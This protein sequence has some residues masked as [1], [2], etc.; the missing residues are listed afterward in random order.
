MFFLLSKGSSHVSPSSTNI[1]VRFVFLLSKRI[2]TEA[3]LILLRSAS[4]EIERSQEVITIHLTYLRLLLWLRVPHPQQIIDVNQPLH[5]RSCWL[6][7][8]HGLF[9]FLTFFD[10]LRGFLLWAFL[11]LGFL[12]GLLLLL[13]LLLWLLFLLLLFPGC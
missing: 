1:S 11:P 4:T 5:R 13:G 2:F 7:C 6:W 3:N 8:L 9:C 12:S 10:R